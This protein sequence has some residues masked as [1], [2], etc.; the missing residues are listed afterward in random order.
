MR[1]S[2]PRAARGRRGRSAGARARP[3]SATRPGSRGRRRPCRCRARATSGDEARDPARLQVL[4]DQHPLLARQAAVVGAG[5]LRSASSFSRSARRSAS[6]RLLTNRIV[7]RCASTSARSSG[8]IEG[9]I[10]CPPARCPVH[11]LAVGGHRVPRARGRAELAQVLDRHDDLEVELLARARVDELGSGRPPET[12]RPISSSGR[13][14]ADRPMRWA[15]ARRAARAAR[16]RAPGARRA[17]CRRPRAPR[18]GSAS[19]RRGASRG[20]RR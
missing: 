7:E 18:R 20:R 19:R 11:R 14:V 12:N 2:R 10:D 13:W 9:Q 15:A 17:S 6:R 3:T 8:Y 5:D 4:L 16:P 1:P